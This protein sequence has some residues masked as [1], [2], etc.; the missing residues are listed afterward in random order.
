MIVAALRISAVVFGLGSL[1]ALGMHLAFAI[2]GPPALLLFLLCFCI[3]A[4]ATSTN[5]PM[6]PK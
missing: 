5:L 2:G 1:T 6:R 3:L 4:F